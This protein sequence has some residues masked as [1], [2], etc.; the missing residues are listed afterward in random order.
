MFIAASA[1][2]SRVEARDVTPKNV[3]QVAFTEIE[4]I[5]ITC[6]ACGGSVTVHLKTW[7]VP[8]HL[9]CP[10]CNRQ[11]WGDGQ[12]RIYSAVVRLAQSLTAWT[13]LQHQAFALGFPLAQ[14]S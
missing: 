8:T 9:A 10:G 7:N 14:K 5:E 6:S 3:I 12:E 2:Q 11:L 4:M 1:V 13:N